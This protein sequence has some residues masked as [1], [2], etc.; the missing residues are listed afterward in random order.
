MDELDRSLIKCLEALYPSYER[1]RSLFFEAGSSFVPPTHNDPHELWV[2]IMLKVS[3]GQRIELVK[4][5]GLA[6]ETYQDNTILQQWYD[7]AA[8]GERAPSAPEPVLRPEASYGTGPAIAVR[9]SVDSE[10]R[11]S[12]ASLKRQYTGLWGF[13]VFW[14]AA[15]TLLPVLISFKLARG[16]ELSWAHVVYV[17][18]HAIGIYTWLHVRAMLEPAYGEG[19]REQEAV[20]LSGWA[21][22]HHAIGIPVMVL[23]VATGL[24]LVR[25]SRTD[26]T[27]WEIP[28]PVWLK[29]VLGIHV[30]VVQPP[31]EDRDSEV[32]SQDGRPGLS[33][34]QNTGYARVAQNNLEWDVALDYSKAA[35]RE[36][37]RDFEAL[38][39][40]CRAELVL[41]KNKDAFAHCRRALRIHADDEQA[42]NLCV[43]AACLNNA[44]KEAHE[45]WNRMQSPDAFSAAVCMNEGIDLKAR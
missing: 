27:F 29:V 21:K 30:D 10:Y 25:I 35:L 2:A 3:A 38:V 34:E 41:R 16:I 11:K 28:S 5:V 4:A 32:S 14:L 15:F 8:R 33:K 23:L 31:S 44:S 6:L 9:G 19:E 37:P 1:V 24:C 43:Q 40:A 42:L 17:I 7:R 12:L 45:C 39:R 36:D 20:R 26:G 13:K 18:Y 22:V